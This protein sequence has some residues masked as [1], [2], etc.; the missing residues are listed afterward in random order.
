MILIIIRRITKQE[1]EQKKN[2]RR[3]KSRN[4]KKRKNVFILL[5]TNPRKPDLGQRRN[6]H[7]RV[8]QVQNRYAM[9]KSSAGGWIHWDAKEGKHSWKD[10]SIERYIILLFSRK[11]LL[12]SITTSILIYWS[13]KWFLNDI[14]QPLS[15]YWP[16]HTVHSQTAVN[17]FQYPWTITW[18]AY[19]YKL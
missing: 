9:L 13:D 19:P 1:Q 10:T 6:I 8:V 11:I 12:Y 2:N 7:K 17:D 5:C 3:T 14:I 4:N 15:E 16:F 18:W